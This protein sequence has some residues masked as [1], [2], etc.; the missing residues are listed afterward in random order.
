MTSAGLWISDKA[1]LAVLINYFFQLRRASATKR[2]ESAVTA[3]RLPLA[4][5]ERDR[6]SGGALHDDTVYPSFT[7]ELDM[8]DMS[9][10]VESL[11]FGGLEEG[12]GRTVDAGWEGHDA[13]IRNGMA[14]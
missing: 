1:S 6:L 4:R 2:R 10:N 5:G 11:F 9:R 12:D 3:Y 8:S 14:G 13:L 7:K